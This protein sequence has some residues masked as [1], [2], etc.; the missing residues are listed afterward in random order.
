MFKANKKDTGTISSNRLYQINW[1]T[2]RPYQ[3]SDQNSELI[4]KLKFEVYEFGLVHLDNWFTSLDHTYLSG[5]AI[6]KQQVDGKSHIF[7]AV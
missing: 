6:S 4:Y 2:S 7:M 5:R 3:K 1:F